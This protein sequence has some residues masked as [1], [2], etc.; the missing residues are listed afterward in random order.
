VKKIVASISTT[1]IVMLFHSVVY[2]QDL[3]DHIIPI[4]KVSDISDFKRVDDALNELTHSVTKCVDSKLGDYKKCA[5]LYPDKTKKLE[6]TIKEVLSKHPEW[7]ENGK[8]LYYYD[9]VEK[10]S[11]N[12][13]ISVIK[14][15]LVTSCKL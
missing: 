3:P 11:S 12:I 8:G 2:G 4:I 1:L 10:R 14:T 9:E 7:G 13:F 15:Q 5:C 6:T